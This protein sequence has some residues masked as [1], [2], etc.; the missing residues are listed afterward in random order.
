MDKYS[1]LKSLL[2]KAYSEV[3]KIDE[4]QLPEMRPRRRVVQNILNY[5]KSLQ[6]Q[7]T[8]ACGTIKFSM[9]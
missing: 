9:N 4:E 3:G 5:S 7:H 8:I 1:T 6:V 2:S